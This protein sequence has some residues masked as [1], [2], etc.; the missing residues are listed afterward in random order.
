MR[1]R[2]AFTLIELLV[3]IAIIAILIGLLL[4]A[5]QKVRAAA[6]RTQCQN[7]LKQLGLACMNYEGANRGFPPAL[8]GYYNP[9]AVPVNW[10]TYVLPY[11]EQANLYNQ[12]DFTSGYWPASSSGNAGIKGSNVNSAVVSTM[13]KTF[14]CPAAPARP[15]PYAVSW[16]F[17]GY[18]PV[19]PYTC[20]NGDYSNI[21]NVDPNEISS[22][23]LGAL[24]PGYNSGSFPPPA[25]LNG[26]LQPDSSTPVT[27][28]TDGT[29]NTILI[30][31]FAGKME[32]YVAGLKDTGQTLLGGPQAPFPNP[33]SGLLLYGGLGGW[34]D[35]ANGADTL[36]GSST[37]GTS[38]PN[39]PCLMNCSNNF[40]MY[41]FHTGGCNAVFADGSVHFLTQGTAANIL[42]ALATMQG[43]EA[44][45]T[46]Y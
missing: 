15:N 4:P 22:L 5:V 23:G 32:L 43:G 34:G 17:P 29:S 1:H 19:G 7:N 38:G 27:A 25:N 2:T 40:G 13:V 14:L 11:I 24:Y 10:G 26:V 41:S 6:A 36:W 37:D 28:I 45:A 35:P 20:A 31:E 44:T 33:T 46:N 8:T 18:P 12:Y 39:G 16:S 9:S 30:T 3:V 42:I 21:L